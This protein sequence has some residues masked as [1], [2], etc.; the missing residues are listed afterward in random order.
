VHADIS[1]III[2]SLHSFQKSDTQCIDYFID[3]YV[4]TQSVPADI[5]D[6]LAAQFLART[7]G[8]Q[9]PLQCSEQHS[10]SCACTPQPAHKQRHLVL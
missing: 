2:G 5:S 8:R 10:T 1:Q 4:A 9:F 6:L 3:A 7:P